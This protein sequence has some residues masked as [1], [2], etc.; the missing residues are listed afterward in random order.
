MKS[1]TALCEDWQKDINKI[2]FKFLFKSFYNFISCSVRFGF[3]AASPMM[4]I[5]TCSI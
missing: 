1:K 4:K 2:H 3:C 5:D